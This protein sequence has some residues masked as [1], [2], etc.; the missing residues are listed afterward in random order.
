MS[1]TDLPQMKRPDRAHSREPSS[2]NALV[3]FL[4]RF[5]SVGV[6]LLLIL[7]F[8][9]AAPGFATIFSVTNLLNATAVF[10]LLALGETFVLFAGG[11]DLS[12]GSMLGLGGVTSAI[13]MSAHASAVGAS[14]V[15]V[16]VGGLLIALG[17]GGAGGAFY[18]AAIAYLNLSPLIVTLGSYGIFLGAADLLSNGLPIENLP[19]ASFTL[20]NNTFLQIPYIAFIAFGLAIVLTFVSKNTRFGLYSYAI[21]TNREAVRRAGVNLKR[22]SVMLYGLCGALAGLAGMLNAVHFSSASSTSGLNDLLVA[23]AAV[24]IGGTPITGG[25]GKVWGTVIGALIYTILQNGFVL[26]N[27]A[28]FWQL[29]VIGFLIM[30]VVSL[31]NYQ[32]RLHS[33]ARVSK[34]LE[35]IAPSPTAS[36]LE[37]GNEQAT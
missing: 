35:S 28:A 13:Y 16:T 3:L 11:I 6:L 12:V 2:P 8:S 17:V 37:D 14:G 4:L 31:D 7:F 29:I 24:V 18:G 33:M 21:G 22:H 19:G 25:E 15:W 23:F 5:T 34:E 20:G 36:P 32:R 30:I 10:L 26:M 27:V 9:I 1:I